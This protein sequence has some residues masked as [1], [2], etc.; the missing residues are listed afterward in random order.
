[1]RAI[2]RIGDRMTAS[3]PIGGAGKAVHAAARP[4]ERVRDECGAALILA[5]VFVVV[6]ALSVGGLLTFAGGSLLDTAQLKAERGLEYGADSATEIAL[7]AVRYRPAY[8][9][10]G[11]ASCLGTPTVKVTEGTQYTFAVYCKGR[12][13]P[14]ATVRSPAPTASIAVVAGEVVVTT[15]NLFSGSVTTRTFVGS[16]IR[17]TKGG[18]PTTPVVTIVSET[19][20]VHTVVLSAAPS[21][22]HQE[23]TDTITLVSVYQRF[24]TFFTCRTSCT[25]TKLLDMMAGRT[26]T[27]SMR[28]PNLVV[29]AEVGFR[30]K[31]ALNGE[32]CNTTATV[33]CGTAILVKQWVV[34]AAND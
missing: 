33:T 11:P 3:R 15:A 28:T 14:V 5:L 9:P 10:T 32:S 7:Q 17:D 18:I 13:A 26:S 6:A 1:M 20:S 16:V 12:L 30:D 8:Y 34:K 2:R 19:N 24:I 29:L 27:P 23:T 21:T 4:S 22:V 25:K 31:T